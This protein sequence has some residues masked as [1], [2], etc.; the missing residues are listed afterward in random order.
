MLIVTNPNGRCS[1]EGGQDE[2]G[3]GWSR[4]PHAESVVGQKKTKTEIPTIQTGDAA[5]LVEEGKIFWTP[6]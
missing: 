3:L 1:S 2:V 6:F 5:N 4:L